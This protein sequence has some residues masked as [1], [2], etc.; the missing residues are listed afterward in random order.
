M[1]ESDSPNKSTSAGAGK[2]TGE[3]H[4][5]PRSVV[6]T[7]PFFA[8]LFLGRLVITQN[9]KERALIIQSR[10][11][12]L[13]I[14]YSELS[15]F[16]SCKK[17][18]IFFFTK[19]GKEKENE[20]LSFGG[21][22]RRN[23]QGFVDTLNQDIARS[24]YEKNSVIFQNAVQYLTHYL[25]DSELEVFSQQLSD[26]LSLVRRH[27][28][29]LQQFFTDEE[30][31]LYACA[32]DF[33]GSGFKETKGKNDEVSLKENADLQADAA[34]MRS[35]HEEY[36]EEKYKDFFDKAE[37]YPLTPAQRLAVIR[38]NDNNL[39]L[40]AAGTGKTSVMVA[41]A[42]YLIKAGLARPEDI[43]ILAYNKAASVE[44]NQRILERSEALNMH[45]LGDLHISTFHALG[46]SIIVKSSGHALLTKFEDDE[47]LLKAWIDQFLFAYLSS[48]IEH[49][50]S[51]VKL[52]MSEITYN[53]TVRKHSQTITTWQGKPGTSVDDD[54]DEDDDAEDS[55]T[56]ADAGVDV[57][58][59]IDSDPDIELRSLNND[60]VRSRQEV[61]IA[62]WLFV[63]SI[64]YKYEDRY[65]SKQRLEPGIDY[66]PDFHIAGTNIYIEHFGIDREGNTAPGIDREHYNE[67][68]KKKRELHQKHGTILL[69]TYSY[70]FTE[71]TIYY[72][73][74]DFMLAH[75]IEIK[76]KSADEILQAVRQNK[77]Y[78]EHIVLLMRCLK[79]I[80]VNNLDFAK[81]KERYEAYGIRHSG[82]YAKFFKDLLDGYREELA[83]QHAIDFDDMIL[84]SA[85]YIKD[86]MFKSHWK[87]I[88]IDEFQDISLSRL[89]LIKELLASNPGTILNAV[90]D[91]W[92]S[93]YRFSG[94]LLEAT[95]RF[96][97]YV[98]P[99]TLT[100][101]EKTYRYNNSI[102]QT[103]GTFIQE[104]PEQFKKT[105]VTHT[106]VNEPK[107]HL[108][109]YNDS[110]LCSAV[111]RMIFKEL[112]PREQYLY[113]QSF[114]IAAAAM[115]L[116][117]AIRQK[118]P[119][120]SIAILSRY[121]NLLNP[122]K[123][124]QRNGRL[125]R[126]SDGLFG[127]LSEA[128][129]ENVKCWTIHRS[130][131]LEADYCII[132]GM[133]GGRYGFPSKV[134][135][136]PLLE[137]LF[138]KLDPY[139][140]S[141]ERRLLYVA[142]TRAKND[143]YLLSSARNASEF[144]EEMLA[145]KYH[146]DIQSKSFNEKMRRIFK[147]PM[148]ANGYFELMQGE[149]GPYY[150][151]STGVKCRSHPRVCEKCGSP[152]IDG[153]YESV[154]QNPRCRH[155][156]KI[157]PVCGRPL[158]LREGKYG[159]FWGCSG[160]GLTEDSCDYTCDYNGR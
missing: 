78:K 112:K 93:I 23:L 137:G 106:V 6:L 156:I 67:L 26:W 132:L 68:I 100:K 113:L 122:L 45:N 94:G 36:I 35:L 105:I 75:H 37:R 56:E 101:L 17:S 53:R 115:E 90:G 48:D 7:R 41:K 21:L 28:S 158:K 104:N 52:F 87:Y 59:D 160:Y 131:G 1:T 51:F 103:A 142:I 124:Y 46:R 13:I 96:E 126:L 139:P 69:E 121:N 148:C 70:D 127:Y 25:R 155:T 66:R 119:K 150:R 120:G 54:L 145:P 14:P 140:F 31:I 65:V 99:Y 15:S 62:D 89:D 71:R 33:K 152:S 4:S 157:C 82:R 98:G 76:K 123:C 77:S 125:P 10:R 129:L 108:Y 136:N 141:E 134:E 39:I 16:A 149:F 2:N 146:L 107:V 57:D 43:L 32:E 49:L 85:Q 79:A 72:K 130:K 135:N 88:L 116:I 18:R 63:N 147:C 19:N 118:D 60:L 83:N 153:R 84:A 64:P 110:T 38:N 20:T 128:E 30:H 12:K 27:G 151:C 109:D 3:N 81:I 34:L 9:R 73:L 111:E 29:M 133:L 80:R 159:K 55:G 144:V 117:K 138:T 22:F 58:A 11:Q 40:A 74:E 47:E 86:D 44:L 92:Q 97:Q 24:I 95:T 8:A 91:D 114:G 42:L 102:A 143:C 61:K 154:C 5:R 50:R